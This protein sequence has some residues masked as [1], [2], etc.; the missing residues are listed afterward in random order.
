MNP[1]V[2]AILTAAAVVGWVIAAVYL[3]KATLRFVD[4]ISDVKDT[5]RQVSESASH[6]GRLDRLQSSHLS[7]IANLRSRLEVVE[8]LQ[9]INKK[10]EDKPEPAV[11]WQGDSFEG[12]MTSPFPKKKGRKK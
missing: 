10:W 8:R 4:W 3:G 11:E 12:G 5:V 2:A 9:S 1:V 7:N 6:Y